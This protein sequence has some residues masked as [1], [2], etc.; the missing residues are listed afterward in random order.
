M[1][2]EE[3]QRQINSEGW[4]EEHDSR[5][6]HGEMAMAATCYAAPERVFVMRE[7]SKGVFFVDPW[8]G[9]W[10]RAWDKRSKHNRLRRLVIAGALIAAE[11]D[12]IGRKEETGPVQGTLPLEDPN[13]DVS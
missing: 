9:R 1:I 4:D 12:R 13:V 8:P 6:T 2:A 3:R 10:S 7:G 11:I 5:H